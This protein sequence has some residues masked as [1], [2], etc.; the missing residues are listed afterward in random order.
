MA[1]SQ[2]ELDR[3]RQYIFRIVQFGLQSPETWRET[4]HLALQAFTLVERR[5]YWREWIPILARVCDLCTDEEL[6]LQCRALNRLG[7]RY[8]EAGHVLAPTASE[9]DRV[10]VDI[11]LGGLYFE[12]ERWERAVGV[13]CCDRY[14]RSR[15]GA[16]SP[17]FSTCHAC[18]YAPKRCTNASGVSA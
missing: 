17:P 18:Q 10:K 14:L 8:Q 3:H 15:P 16:H 6:S 7:Q 1:A 13:A 2:G 9:L 5:G 11:A 12:L 4:G